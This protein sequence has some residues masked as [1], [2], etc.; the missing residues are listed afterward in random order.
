MKPLFSLGRIVATPGALALQVNFALYL[1]MHQRGYWGEICQE[2]WQANDRSVMAGE[3]LLSAYETGK[4][5]IWIITEHDRSVTT[6][7]LPS[8]Y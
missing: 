4:G 1:G 7:L 5:K 3:R 2:D 8:E 6:I